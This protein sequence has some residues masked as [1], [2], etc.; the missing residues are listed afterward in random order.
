MRAPKGKEKPGQT[1]K[2][3]HLCPG[4]IVWV[5]RQWESGS[6]KEKRVLPNEIPPVG[7]RRKR[8]KGGTRPIANLQKKGSRGKK[9][10][11][12]EERRREERKLRSPLYYIEITGKRTKSGTAAR[13]DWTA[14][15]K[16]IRAWGGERRDS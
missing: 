3:L 5:G 14:N 10:K 6:I 9:I 4:V 13:A 1:R 7:E 16:K 11:R 12:R 15:V 8:I 2:L